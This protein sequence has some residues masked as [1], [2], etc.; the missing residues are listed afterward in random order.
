MQHRQ[1]IDRF[2]DLFAGL[3]SRSPKKGGAWFVVLALVFNLAAGFA[4]PSSASAALS[5]S[6]TPEQSIGND[7]N[8]VVICSP[9]GIRIMF[10]GPDG[11]P[12]PE[13][14]QRNMNCVHCLSVSGCHG[15]AFHTQ[16]FEPPAPT[17]QYDRFP[18]D[19]TDIIAPVS[20]SST[21]TIRAPPSRH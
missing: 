6:A 17:R 7:V 15:Y 14:P 1:P 9:N 10:V 21:D 13:P 3:R 4:L 18:A 11:E 16:D 20:L 19:R 12:F 2:S 8:I 5:D